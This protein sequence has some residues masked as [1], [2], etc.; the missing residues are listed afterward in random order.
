MMLKYVD[1]EK[2]VCVCMC[3]WGGECEWLSMCV[4]VNFQRAS[5]NVIFSSL[6]KVALQAL[7]TVVKS[8]FCPQFYK[9]YRMWLGRTIYLYKIGFYAL[10]AWYTMNSIIKKYFI[11]RHEI[12]ST[13][14][15]YIEDKIRLKFREIIFICFW[16]KKIIL[17]K[18]V[19]LLPHDSNYKN[20]PIIIKF[21]TV[22]YFHIFWFDIINYSHKKW[23]ALKVK[24]NFGKS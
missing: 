17:E 16:K 9:E 4:C 24:R 14:Y 1:F 12:L 20:Y 3:V 23:N 21:W 15:T 13:Y 22:I 7:K 8:Y 19:F 11:Y 18:I 2:I 6:H 10:V 5:W